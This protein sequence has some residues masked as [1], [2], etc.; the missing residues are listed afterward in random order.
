MFGLSAKEGSLAGMQREALVIDN[1]L[2]FSAA[3][4]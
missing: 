1:N 4:I 3:M 2:I